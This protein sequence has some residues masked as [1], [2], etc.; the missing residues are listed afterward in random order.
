MHFNDHFNVAGSH[1]FLSPSSYHWI[2]YDQ[3]K[4][5]DRYITHTL[6][7]RGT[8]LHDFAHNAIKLK[9]KMAK[10]KLT[11]NMFVNDVLG[12]RMTSEQALHY[13]NNCFGTADA[14]GYKK[15]P[16]N[17]EGFDGLLQIFDLKTGTT[18]GHVEQLQVYAALFI[19]EYG[20]ALGINA[21]SIQYDLRIYQSDEIVIFD[22]D[23]TEIV[24]IIDKIKTFDRLIEEWKLEE[25]Q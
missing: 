25:A 9:I 15:Y 2:R 7:K 6:A 16:R 22:V 20:E 12:Y 10:S 5:A 11:L 17:A 13:S 19:L 14:I 18:P 4:L 1:A 23:P 21:F 3:E 24:A 8:D